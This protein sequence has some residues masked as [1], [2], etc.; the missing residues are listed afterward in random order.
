MCLRWLPNGDGIK[1]MTS[2]VHDSLCKPPDSGLSI[3]FMASNRAVYI[4]VRYI[5]IFIGLNSL[6]WFGYHLV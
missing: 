4:L 1:K 3:H 2:K 6:Q 5:H